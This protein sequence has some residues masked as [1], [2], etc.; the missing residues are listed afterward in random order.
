MGEREVTRGLGCCKRTTST[1]ERPVPIGIPPGV[2]LLA[3]G[4]PRDFWAT[5]GCCPPS[6]SGLKR[7]FYILSHE[8]LFS[9]PALS[10]FFKQL[11]SDGSG[12]NCT[13]KNG[14]RAP[15]EAVQADRHDGCALFLLS[16]SLKALW[17]PRKFKHPKRQIPVHSARDSSRHSLRAACLHTG[18]T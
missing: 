12:R 7:P 5:S 13:G 6:P 2:C 9:M 17:V 16:C 10:N 8:L 11:P 18:E 15:R 3:A 14:A 4:G 1:C